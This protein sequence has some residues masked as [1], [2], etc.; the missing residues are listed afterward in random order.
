M[1]RTIKILLRLSGIAMIGVAMLGGLPGPYPT[2]IGIA[3]VIMFFA[4]G[5]T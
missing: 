1:N 5:T 4:S 3:G 2:L